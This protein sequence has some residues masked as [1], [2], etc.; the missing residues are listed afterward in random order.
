MQL[1][2]TLLKK[3]EDGF[4]TAELVDFLAKHHISV[5]AHNLTRYL[6][7]YGVT[8]AELLMKPKSPSSTTEVLYE[9]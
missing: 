4:T 5:K 1:A 3:K 2:P 6:R 9:P 7:E 8:S